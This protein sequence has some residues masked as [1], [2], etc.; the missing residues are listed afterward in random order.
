MEKRF[1][2]LPKNASAFRFVESFLVGLGL[3]EA[4]REST[5]DSNLI[6]F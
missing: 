5:H 3:Q 6:E 1:P 4:L 2:L